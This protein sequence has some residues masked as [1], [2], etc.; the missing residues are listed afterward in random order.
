[1]IQVRFTTS[2]GGLHSSYIEGQTVTLPTPLPTP[3]DRFLERGIIVP[4]RAD[5][6]ER[7]VVDRAV[8]VQRGSTRVRGK[9][10]RRPA[11]LA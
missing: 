11:A 3:F 4:V 10:A 2:V 6:I 8:L 5:T 1:M 7:A 9:R